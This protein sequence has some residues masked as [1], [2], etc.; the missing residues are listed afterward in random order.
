M[1]SQRSAVN[2]YVKAM[3]N[4]KLGFA[5]VGSF[6][7]WVLLIIAFQQTG[8]DKM[9]KNTDNTKEIIAVL[10]GKLSLPLDPRNIVK[11]SNYHLHSNL[12]GTL[13]AS[14]PTEAL[15]SLKSVSKD[16]L[17]YHLVLKSA[18]KFSDGSPILM[19]DV[20]ASVNRLLATLDSGH[21]N[22]K[23]A[24]E[25][26]R[27]IDDRELEFK[28]HQV[29]PSFQFLLSIPEMGIV[30]EKSVV[31]DQLVNLKVTSGAYSLVEHEGERL[32]LK[33]NPH[34]LG[35]QPLS[36][37]KVSLRF[38]SDSAQLAEDAKAIGAHFIEAS[39]TSEVQ[40]MR[41]LSGDSQYTILST[42][43]SLSFY[44]LLNDRSLSEKQRIAISDLV[45]RNLGYELDPATEK[46]SFELSP[47]K[48]FASLGLSS[49]LT[50][51]KS[52]PEDLPP[53]VKMVKSTSAL[54]EAIAST[55]SK[56][57]VDIA[58]IDSSEAKDADIRV[59][60]QGMNSD[61][62]EIEYHLLLLSQWAAF[63]PQPGE[64]EL[65]MKALHEPDNSK[66]AEYI[67]RVSRAMV[68]DARAVPLLVRS[69]MHAI[70][71]S[72]LEVPKFS[73]YD[74]DVRFSRMNTKE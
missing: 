14:N 10:S 8:K 64:E 30:P 35:H 29:T 49:S 63:T 27:A 4:K 66:R 54:N 72:V 26:V 2:P 3:I 17:K 9:H 62:P 51:L 42:R 16:G 32:E 11:I 15:A 73:D 50:A 39:N 1:K 34:Y 68:E 52:K 12:W 41:R 43:P 40:S 25:S 65:I 74:G 45:T 47:P 57:G 28:L 53:K 61:F 31:N 33:K 7:I 13:L 46:R 70:D 23:T 24:I 69:Y 67:Q 21:F 19:S 60:S 5:L 20:I 18:I 55:L 56:A 36:P 59:R 37:H 48:T 44:A 71:H 38:M 6:L 22:P 58:W